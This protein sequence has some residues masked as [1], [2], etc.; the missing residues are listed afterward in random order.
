VYASSASSATSVWSAHRNAVTL[1]VTAS[2]P[3]VILQRSRATLTA[4]G[5]ARPS[6]RWPSDRLPAHRPQPAHP[7]HLGHAAARQHP[8]RRR[9]ATTRNPQTPAHHPRRA[10]RAAL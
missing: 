4:P 5:M 8:P 9:R 1:S 7:H 10:S 3:P 6:R 2:S